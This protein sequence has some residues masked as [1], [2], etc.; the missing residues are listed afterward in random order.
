[1][2]FFS[3]TLSKCEKN[4]AAIEREALA[5]VES[6]RKFRHFLAPAPFSIVTDQEAVSFIFNKQHVGKIKNEKLTRWRIE[7]L[8]YDF[9]IVFRPGKLNNSADPQS[10]P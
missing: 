7:L 4:Q 3:R 9:S 5:I 10:Q 8:T 2:A 6:V 1:M